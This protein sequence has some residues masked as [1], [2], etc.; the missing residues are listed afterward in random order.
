YSVSDR[1]VREVEGAWKPDH[2]RGS[3]VA[4]AVPNEGRV[5]LE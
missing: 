2:A 1:L 5:D 3:A 4:P